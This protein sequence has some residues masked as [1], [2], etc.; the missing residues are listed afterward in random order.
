MRERAEL[1]GGKLQVTPGEGD[2]TM[3]RLRVP[4][5]SVEAQVG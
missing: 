2:G 5:E 3:V 1:V 4:R